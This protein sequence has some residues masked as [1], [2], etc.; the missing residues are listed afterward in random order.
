MENAKRS[1][2]W[3]I[4]KK[5]V[6]IYIKNIWV[7]IAI[8]LVAMIPQ[9][10][11][12]YLS[13][14]GKASFRTLPLGLLNIFL[15]VL[16]L[17]ALFFIFAAGYRGETVDFKT[18][19]MKGLKMWPRMFVV[20]LL[21]GLATGLGMLL[22]IV[23]GVIF[24][25]KYF[26]AIPAALEEDKTEGPMGRG[27]KL[28]KGNMGLI[29]LVMFCVYLPL[30]LPVSFIALAATGNPLLFAAG[31]I[32]FGLISTI[33][34]AVH[35]AAY[36]GAVE[37]AV[38]VESGQEAPKKQ[39]GVLGGC[40]I[41]AAVTAVIIAAIAGGVYYAYKYVGFGRIMRMCTGSTMKLTTE[42]VCTY[43][44]GW[45]GLP[46]NSGHTSF[47]VMHGAITGDKEN[48]G[49]PVAFFRAV[50]F[51]QEFSLNLKAVDAAGYII[52]MEK[53]IA[54]STSIQDHTP[55]WDVPSGLRSEEVKL[56]TL[57]WRRIEL[58]GTDDDGEKGQWRILYARQGG[59]LAY[60]YYKSPDKK[61]DME[62]Y[63]ADE[64]EIYGMVAAATERPE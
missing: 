62:L 58:D 28:S 14:G 45:Y 37:A 3:E 38:P 20:A 5:G 23:P 43:P 27:A 55:H 30:M 54:D 57:K 32:V 50:P 22:L 31:F 15:P 18:A 9:I 25:A 39:I 35:Y 49:M 44:D 16:N 42:I 56:G 8:D 6:S 26:F 48:I 33:A 40:L 7:I 63:A 24:A 29:Y 60:F 53:E 36:A 10:L 17:G 47:M 4:V 51:P 41:A 19:F 59:K 13:M 11:Y 64:K 2:F 12:T 52:D 34:Q 21:Y 46:I 61:T 1:G